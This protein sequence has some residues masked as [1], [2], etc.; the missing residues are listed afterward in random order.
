MHIYHTREDQKCTI[1]DFLNQKLNPLSKSERVFL[2]LYDAGISAQNLPEIFDKLKDYQIVELSLT[3]NNLGNNEAQIIAT[4]LKASKIQKVILKNNRIGDRGASAIAGAIVSRKPDLE[5]DLQNNRIGPMGGTALLEAAIQTH[6]K[7]F[8]LTSNNLGDKGAISIANVLK[9][10]QGQLTK[11][12]LTYNDIGIAGDKALSD[13]VPPSIAIQ[14]RV[15]RVS[16]MEA[17]PIWSFLLCFFLFIPIFILPFIKC[18]T[19]IDGLEHEQ[20]RRPSN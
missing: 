11:L 3:Y 9:G 20:K 1:M 16:F 7:T 15:K 19:S 18:D 4:A 13:N 14:Y 17:H 8:D 12:V 5:V 6:A 10:E 2:D